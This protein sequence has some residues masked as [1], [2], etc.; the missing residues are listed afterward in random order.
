M[1]KKGKQERDKDDIV[2]MVNIEAVIQAIVKDLWNDFDTDKNGTL[3]R[4]ETME[5]L[6]R[7]IEEIQESEQANSNQEEKKKELVLDEDFDACFK[8]LDIDN[9]G[10]IEQDEMVDIIRRVI[11]IGDKS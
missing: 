4:E 7:T 3:D 5:F 11:G 1:E 6:R 8:V 10:A 2:F 9:S